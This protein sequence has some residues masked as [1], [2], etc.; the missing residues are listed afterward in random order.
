MIVSIVTKIMGDRRHTTR[1]KTK[2]KL[3]GRIHNNGANI[4]FETGEE[5]H[6]VNCDLADHQYVK[7]HQASD[8]RKTV[9]QGAVAG[10]F[11]GGLLGGGVGAGTGATIGAVIGSII[12]GPGT[13]I[14][15]AVGATIGGIAGAATVGGVGVAT[16]AGVAA[17]VSQSDAF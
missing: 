1:D 17:A 9:T 2:L 11:S 6:A 5:R 12:P 4:D 13:I 10:F 16:G 14:G 8:K 7:S 3:G 15:A